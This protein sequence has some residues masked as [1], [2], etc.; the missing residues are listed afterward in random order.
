MLLYSLKLVPVD[1]LISSLAGMWRECS[2]FVLVRQKQ[3]K[4]E[5]LYSTFKI[6]EGATVNLSN[7]NFI[8]QHDQFYFVK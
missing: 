4:L 7:V 2:L 1:S 8:S 5:F 6:D 3:D